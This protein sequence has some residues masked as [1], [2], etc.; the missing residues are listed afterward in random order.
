MREALSH[1]VQTLSGLIGWGA[2][3][4]VRLACEKRYVDLPFTQQILIIYVLKEKGMNTL[5]DYRQ[6]TPAIVQDFSGTNAR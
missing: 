2:R 4:Y 6:C 3:Q 1:F 5:G